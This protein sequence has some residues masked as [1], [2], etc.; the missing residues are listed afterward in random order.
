MVMKYKEK[1]LDKI[2]KTA[3]LLDIEPE[4]ELNRSILEAWKENSSM[5]KDRKRKVAI[6]VAACMI[7]ATG[8]VLA[9]TKY[10]KMGEVAE[11]SGIE[12]EHSFFEENVTE[13]NETKEAGEYRFTLLGIAS[14]EAWVQSSLSQQITDLQGM[15][16][17][18]AIERLDGTS[19]ADTSD[20]Q[21][22][23]LRFFI[24][25]LIAGLKPWQYNIVSM[26]GGYTDIVEDGIL[27]RL[28]SC[29]DIA[30]F[31]DRELYLCI[32]DTVFYDTNAYQYDENSGKISRNTEYD[33]INLL[34]SLPIDAS[35]ADRAAAAAYLERLEQSWTEDSKDEAEGLEEVEKL[36][37]QLEILLADGKYEEALTG[38]AAVGE[39]SVIAPDKDGTYCYEYS[40][41]T[42]CTV[43]YFYPA[44]FINGRDYMISYGD[45]EDGW[46]KVIILVLTENEDKTVTV[47]RYE[48]KNE[49]N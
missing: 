17:A 22:A 43:S 21:Y 1:K 48:K 34:F 5:K 44:N 33:G 7:L 37:S 47:Q 16:A 26:N 3:L 42:E 38:F 4:E 13:I 19:M 12:M 2:L 40:D 35:K 9:A 36:M 27:Y 24:S 6:A 20:E 18:V 25:P 15:Y 49:L 11:K 10:L 29:D 41:E 32:S 39:L 23:E 46:V 8:S 14:G 31:A 45:S 28:I 30:L